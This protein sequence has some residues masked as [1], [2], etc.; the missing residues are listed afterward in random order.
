[1]TTAA[2]TLRL[3]AIAHSPGLRNR[4]CFDIYLVRSFHSFGASHNDELKRI[5]IQNLDNISIKGKRVKQV[6]DEYYICSLF[7]K[8]KVSQTIGGRKMEDSLG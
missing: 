2:L 4:L 7:F 6:Q 5:F 8:K 3:F 1:M